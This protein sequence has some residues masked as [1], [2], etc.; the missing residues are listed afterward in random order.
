MTP[1]EARRNALWFLAF[2]VATVACMGTAALW[3]ERWP[4]LLLLYIVPLAAFGVLLYLA[5]RRGRID[6]RFAASHGG[7]TTGMSDRDAQDDFNLSQEGLRSAEVRALHQERRRHKA[8][9]TLLHAFG[10]TL[11]SLHT[12]DAVTVMHSSYSPEQA[13]FDAES[14]KLLSAMIDARLH[15]E[16]DRKVRADYRLWLEQHPDTFAG[17]EREAMLVALA[18]VSS[19]DA[20]IAARARELEDPAL[21]ALSESDRALYAG[22]LDRAREGKTELA[23]SSALDLA[24]RYPRVRTLQSFACDL[25]K[26]DEVQKKSVEPPCARAAELAKAP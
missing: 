15:G 8:A 6:T 20:T 24:E 21:S 22:A 23:L 11:G 25:G 19:H 1:T 12:A 9:L 7:F 4:A 14:T 13:T 18:D 5:R 3:G 16:D 10:H 2:S 26:Q 17:K